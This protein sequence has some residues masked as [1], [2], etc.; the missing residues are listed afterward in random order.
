MKFQERAL[1]ITVALMVT[2]FVA[3]T[4]PMKGEMALGSV[5]P[6]TDGYLN[7]EGDSSGSFLG[8]KGISN[9]NV[10]TGI[11]VGLL[12]LG[13]FSTLSDTRSINLAS[14]GTTA[15]SANSLNNAILAGANNKPIYDVLRSLPDD[16]SEIVKLIDAAAQVELLRE[17]NSYTFFAPTN[18][19][20]DLISNQLR[21]PENREL[22]VKL[23][24]RH[25]IQGRYTISKLLSLKNGTILKTLTGENAIITNRNGE[26][27]VNNIIVSQSDLNA[28]NGYIHPIQAPLDEQ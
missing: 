15:A 27:R 20:T 19:A 26:L 22:L 1:R 16:F 14:G 8:I 23:I 21:M 3:S 17:D 24:R 12:G 10:I 6:P 5:R 4:I 13:V 18:V 25:T 9:S 7:P 28:S 2:G 11:G